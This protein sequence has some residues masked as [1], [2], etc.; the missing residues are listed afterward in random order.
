MGRD[1]NPTRNGGPKVNILTGNLIENTFHWHCPVESVLPCDNLPQ[2]KKQRLLVWN[3]VDGTPAPVHEVSNQAHHHLRCLSEIPLNV[4]QMGPER[5]QDGFTL[6]ELIIV[7]VILGILSATALPKFADLGGDARKAVVN[8]ARSS[9][10]VAVAM[11]HGKS[12]VT[13]SASATVVLEGVSVSMV[14]GYPTASVDLANAAGLTA[15]DWTITVDGRNL[16]VSPTSASTS[17][18]C[19]VTYFEATSYSSATLTV[20]NTGC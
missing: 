3:A 12:L 6:I 5:N 15:N 19:K 2:S 1:A 4:S 17:D 20:V 7:I 13:G 11:S 16:I 14:N 9:L 18:L 8:A 10:E